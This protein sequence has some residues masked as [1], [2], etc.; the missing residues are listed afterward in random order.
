MENL[1][2]IKDLVVEF[3]AALDSADAGSIAT[4]LQQFTT[5]DYYWR[6]MHPFYEQ[7]GAD[8]VAD[9]FWEP[10]RKAFAPI[11][12]RADIFF[13][14]DNQIDSGETRWVAQMGHLMGLF[15][16]P[17]LGI[18]PTGKMVFLPFVEFNRVENGKICET[19]FFCDIISVMKQAGLQPLP[20]QTGAFII[21]PGPRTHDGLLYGAQDEDESARTL[22]LINRMCEE[23]TGSGMHSSDDE[24]RNTWHEDMIWYGPTGI[25]ATYTISRYEMQHQGPFNAGLKD[26]VFNGHVAR[27]AEGNFGGWFGWAN[28]SMK[29]SGGFLG[30]NASDTPTEMRVVDLYRREGDKLA[31]NWVFIDILHFLSMQGLDVLGRLQGI[32][33]VAHAK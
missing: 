26:I 12:R 18:P 7:K 23:L 3:H 19:A 20:E 5:D 27:F 2:S 33:T 10:L 22:K 24:L 30:L 21:Q 29:T 11:Q 14:G 4:V 32:H 13:A 28:L 6:G 15:D 8:A 1:Q 16:Q 31:E 25:G 17:W 9:V